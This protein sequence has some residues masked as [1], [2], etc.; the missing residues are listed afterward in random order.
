MAFPYA[1]T[2]GIAGLIYEQC[3]L[4][5]EDFRSTVNA[6]DGYRRLGQ[7][8]QQLRKILGFYV[9]NGDL[10]AFISKSSRLDLD[11]AS[12]AARKS[13]EKLNDLLDRHDGIKDA[14]KEWWKKFLQKRRFLEENKNI[15]DLKNEFGSHVKILKL[16]RSNIQR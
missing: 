2:T 12:E 3:V 14:D 11:E 1:G 4:V 10:E 6:P 13:I 5:A 8:V 7:E 16:L 15:E 9:E